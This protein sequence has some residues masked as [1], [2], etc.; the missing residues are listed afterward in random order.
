VTPLRR[1]YSARKRRRRSCMDT[2]RSQ[3]RF[4]QEQ[5]GGAVQQA[6]DQLAFHA[7][8]QREV[9]H[10]SRE[11]FSHVQQIDELVDRFAKFS[12]WHAV[13]FRQ[14]FEG[15]HG[16]NIPQE[17]AFVPHH[18]RDAAQERWLAFPGVEAIHPYDAIRRIQQARHHF[19]R[20]CLTSPV[21]SD[22]AD[23]LARSVPQN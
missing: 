16:L 10:R 1:L 3:G 22:E 9:A 23:H 13:D 12:R 5:H 19:Q 4:I 7:F 6:C 18:H 21:G 15:I 17:L 2:S 20:G 11:Q 8:P 14:H